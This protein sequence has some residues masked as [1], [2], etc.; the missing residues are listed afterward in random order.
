MPGDAV[1]AQPLASVVVNVMPDGTLDVRG[2][3]AGRCDSSGRFSP[4][5][6]G[7]YIT[8][9]LQ[10]VRSAAHSPEPAP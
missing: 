10:E 7:K 3:I 9:A 6:A 8:K 5:D 2:Y 1:T 4:A